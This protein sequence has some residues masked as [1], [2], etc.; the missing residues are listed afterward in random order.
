M[1][2]MAH[3]AGIDAACSGAGGGRRKPT[4][5]TKVYCVQDQAYDADL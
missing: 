1:L 5:L 3:A 4:E 2:F